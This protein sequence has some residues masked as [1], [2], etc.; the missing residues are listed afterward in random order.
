M[1]LPLIIIGLAFTVSGLRAEAVPLTPANPRFTYYA[2]FDGEDARAVLVNLSY[3][4]KLKCYVNEGQQGSLTYTFEVSAGASGMR[5]QTNGFTTND[6]RSGIEGTY[7]VDGGHAKILFNTGR[8][9]ENGMEIEPTGI[10]NFANTAP[11]RFISDGTIDLDP[12]KKHTVVLTISSNGYG[13]W[14]EQ[15]LRG[16]AQEL[17]DEEGSPQSLIVTAQFK[18]TG[19]LKKP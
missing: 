12:L 19:K 3:S 9:I 13:D 8:S 15:I 11:T 6:G 7:S 4:D 16:A 5:I 10:P 14:N 18:N 1:K 17:F 2:A